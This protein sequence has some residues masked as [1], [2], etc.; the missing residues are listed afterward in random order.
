MWVCSF[1]SD[2]KGEGSPLSVANFNGG[3]GAL[4]TMLYCFCERAGYFC[5]SWG[6]SGTMFAICRLSV[7]AD[8]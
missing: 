7:G 6:E 1:D 5:M 8:G 4:V 2:G 3:D